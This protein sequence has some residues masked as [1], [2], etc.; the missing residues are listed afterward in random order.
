MQLKDG[1]SGQQIGGIG[2]WINWLRWLDMILARL[3]LQ[4]WS[5]NQAHV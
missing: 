5:A 3:S 1:V 2:K 4:Q